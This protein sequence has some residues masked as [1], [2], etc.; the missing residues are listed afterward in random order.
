MKK[1][2]IV[3]DTESTGLNAAFSSIVQVAA[4]RFDLDTFEVLDKFDIR[5]RMKKEYPI[6]H[7]KSLLINHV[8]IDQ[9]KNHENSNFQLINKMRSRC[10]EWGESI[11]W[12]W[13]NIGF[14][15]HMIRQ[16]LFQS[17]FNP[18]LSNTL[19]NTE[20]DFLKLTHAASITHPN[21]FVRPINDKGK[22]TFQLEKFGPANN[23]HAEKSHDALSDV[24][25]TLRVG[26]M[27]RDK[28][29]DVWQDSLK[30]CSKKDTYELINQN[31]IFAAS[32]WYN[33][34]SYQHAL[35]FLGANPSYENE[36]Y[37]FDV[38]HDPEQIFELDRNELKELFKGKEKAF[39]M[40]KANQHMI[41]LDEKYIF[42][43]D[44]YKNFSSEEL[45]SRMKKIRSNKSFKEKFMNLLLDMHEDK[46]FT[47][48]QSEKLVENSIYD[49]FAS[50]KDNYLMRDFHAA[51]VENKLD[52]ANKIEDVRYREFAKRVLYNEY[53]E[54][55]TKK[56]LILRDKRVA[57]NHLTLD[58]KPWVTIPAAM[59][60]VDDLRANENEDENIDLH[61]LQEIDEYLCEM[62]S[63]FE[64]FLKK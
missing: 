1:F 37:F 18:Y 48:D 7:P 23:I 50:Q 10:L 20:G 28:C 36:I 14:D 13:N 55:L 59:Q 8:S 3:I 30:T 51:T 39:V 45:N 63:K 57:E 19:G 56:E 27:I 40:G 64:G 60:V 47:K 62:Q 31:K 33:G 42:Q 22:I 34:R 4:I 41:L 16:A 44:D 52:I 38:R 17:C 58:E 24:S 21:S 46:E 54:A 12:G 15:R 61:K 29:P 49:G 32:N 5:G 53:P 25:Q 6:F 11:Y 9:I 2:G 43:N 35:V 26:K